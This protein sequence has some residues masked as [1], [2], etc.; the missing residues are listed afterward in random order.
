MLSIVEK[1]FGDARV[2]EV[3]GV[4]EPGAEGLPEGGEH[5]GGGGGSDDGYAT[6]GNVLHAIDGKFGIDAER[7]G[8]LHVVFCRAGWEG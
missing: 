7:E 1:V 3:G 5:A 8:G 4:A 2:A 6:A